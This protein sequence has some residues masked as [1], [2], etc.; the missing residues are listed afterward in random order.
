M[1]FN[2][3]VFATQQQREQ[4]A[5]MQVVTRRINY[6]VHTEDNRVEIT[7]DTDDAEAMQLI[8]RLQDGIVAAVAMLLYHLFA[9]TG[10]R[11]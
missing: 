3:M 4:L 8:P 10:E 1:V 6:V 11:V 9:M 2:P 5:K 7:L